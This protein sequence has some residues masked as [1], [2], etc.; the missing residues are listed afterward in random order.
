MDGSGQA[1]DYIFCERLW[2][3]GNTGNIYLRQYNS[4]IPL[5]AGLTRYFDFYNHEKPRQSLTIA[6]RSV[7]SRPHPSGCT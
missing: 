4:V 6:R 3:S 2:R 7:Q 1:L 5:Q